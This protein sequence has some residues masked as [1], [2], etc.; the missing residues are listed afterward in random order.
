MIISTQKIRQLHIKY[1]MV[2]ENYNKTCFADSF[3]ILL[4]KMQ[5]TII[6]SLGANSYLIVI[7]GSLNS[8]QS[9]S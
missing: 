7:K 4:N 1:H 2:I 5:S 3:S 9:I 8:A 6:N